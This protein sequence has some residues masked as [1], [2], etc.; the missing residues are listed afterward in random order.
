MEVVVMKDLSDLFPEHK[1]SLSLEHN[2]HK[3]Y[4]ETIERWEENIKSC[5]GHDKSDS[6]TFGW[7][8]VEQRDK[9]IKEDSVWCLQWYPDTPIGSC[10]LFACDLEV[11][12]TAAKE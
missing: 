8:S 9:A 1:C 4:Y 10:R 7:V 2:Q 5:S 6:V 3:S 11:L 12:L